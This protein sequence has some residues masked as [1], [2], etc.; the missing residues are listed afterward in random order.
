[1]NP[2]KYEKDVRAVYDQKLANITDL[3]EQIVTGKVTVF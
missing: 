2:K 3:T 1:V